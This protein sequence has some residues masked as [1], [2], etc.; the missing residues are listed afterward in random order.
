MKNNIQNLD[1]ESHFERNS[2]L[3]GYGK[4]PYI[5]YQSGHAI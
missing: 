4:F 3:H 1:N 5:I 2:F